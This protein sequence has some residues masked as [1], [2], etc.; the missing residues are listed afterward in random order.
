MAE[1]TNTAS[2]SIDQLTRHN[3]PGVGSEGIL[4][5]HRINT[6]S[7]VAASHSPTVDSTH[8]FRERAVSVISQDNIDMNFTTIKYTQ[9]DDVNM[10]EDNDSSAF[11]D[12]TPVAPDGGWGWVIV[13]A[14]FGNF[15]QLGLVAAHFHVYY[16][17][18]VD[19][20]QADM[21]MAGWIGSLFA[22]TGNFL[23]KN[24]ITNLTSE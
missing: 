11:D 21:G 15:F 2:S 20:F 16:V 4:G 14:C 7:S 17:A 18:I 9:A 5:E 1:I 23:G 19:H 6:G 10:S 13:A 8:C 24:I 3:T 12:V 22:F